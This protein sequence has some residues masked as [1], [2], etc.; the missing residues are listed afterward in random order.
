MLGHRLAA[1]ITV[2]ELM[3]E[4]DATHSSVTR[5]TDQGPATARTTAAPGLLAGQHGDRSKRP[6]T[7]SD[8]S[9]SDMRTDMNAGPAHADTAGPSRSHCPQAQPDSFAEYSDLATGI[10]QAIDVANRAAEHAELAA[11]QARDASKAAELMVQRGRHIAEQAKTSSQPPKQRSLSGGPATHPSV[12]APVPPAHATSAQPA[13]HAAMEALSPRRITRA[14]TA[15][16]AVAAAQRS[17]LPVLAAAAS[18]DPTAH[19]AAMRE[20]PSVVA[21]WAEARRRAAMPDTSPGSHGAASDTEPKSS[22][23][24][25]QPAA[26]LPMPQQNRCAT[27]KPIKVKI[28]GPSGAE[29]QFTC[30]PYCSRETLLKAYTQHC[31]LKPGGLVLI[32]K[33]KKRWDTLYW[34]G[35]QEGEVLIVR[36]VLHEDDFLNVFLR[37]QTGHSLEFKCRYSRTRVGPLAL[38]YSMKSGIDVLD[39]R[40]LFNGCRMSD[41]DLLDDYMIDSGDIIDVMLAQVGD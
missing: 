25:S 17:A 2:G 10:H 28:K 1:P 36:P 20:L 18:T 37:G 34:A 41:L 27:D 29:M 14:A 16:A 6:R 26:P 21:E 23:P 11:K 35:A 19:A 30:N 8:D 13:G 24:A 22:V 32:C 31:G 7:D 33:D 9:S 39:L 38:V 12:Q 4:F 15:A 5:K 3:Q 40:V